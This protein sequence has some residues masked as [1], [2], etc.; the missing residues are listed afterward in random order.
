[1]GGHTL[2]TSYGQFFPITT[3]SFLTP[4][5]FLKTPLALAF[6]SP[7]PTPGLPAPGSTSLPT[8]LPGFLEHAADCG[9]GDDEGAD[10]GAALH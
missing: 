2:Y 3:G 10:E 6:A 7:S 4:S 8:K 5:F 1:M 9:C